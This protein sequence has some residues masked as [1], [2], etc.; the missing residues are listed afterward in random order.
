M[1]Y[2][3]SVKDENGEY[4]HIPVPEE[5]Y[6]YVRQLEICIKYPNKSHLLELYP[7]RF[8]KRIE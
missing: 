3:V 1:N 7:E 2:Y 6:V 4:K 5:V 8:D